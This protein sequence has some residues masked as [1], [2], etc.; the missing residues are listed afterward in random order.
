MKQR[1]YIAGQVSG[2]DFK[3]VR[4]QFA[5]AQ[6]DLA[7][8]G[9][10]PVNPVEFIMNV[11]KCRKEAGL[12]GLTDENDRAEIMVLCLAELSECDAIY[13]LPGYKKSKGAMLERHFAK[14]AGMK[15]IYPK[16]NE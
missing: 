12:D 1:Y 5:V 6:L 16:S 7:Q 2:K 3:A 14:V 4:K 11:N 8:Q 13:L 10:E 15:I 9:I